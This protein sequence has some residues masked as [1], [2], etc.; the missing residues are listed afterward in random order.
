MRA[1]QCHHRDNLKDNREAL[2]LLDK[3]IRLDPGFAAAYGWKACTIGQAWARGYREFTQDDENLVLGLIREGLSKDQNDIECA[4]ISCEFHMEAQQFE[5]ARRCHDK[6]FQLNPNDPRIVAQRGDLEIWQG[7]PEEG[8]T[9]IQ[10]AIQLDPLGADNFA[11][12]QGRALFSLRRYD[13]SLLAF[14]KV[15]APQ[16][17]HRAYMAACYAWL[18]QSK[19]ATL[20]ANEVLAEKTDFSATKFTDSLFYKLESDKQNLLEGLQK[21]GLPA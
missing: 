13:E 6:A 17:D 5:D 10:L 12:L 18:E 16:Y 3:A 19:E 4:R 2:E 11:H 1:K 8:L 14:K 9:W 7:K 15:P 20:L 21:S